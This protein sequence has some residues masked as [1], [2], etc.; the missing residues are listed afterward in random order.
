MEG[1]GIMKKVS[2]R[3]LSI[4]LMLALIIGLN[5]SFQ[6][7]SRAAE[8]DSL[9]ELQCFLS[10][11]DKLP[12][13]YSEV[14][15]WENG[16][17]RNIATHPVMIGDES[18]YYLHIYNKDGFTF[19]FKGI[20]IGY[21][22]EG[23]SIFTSPVNAEEQE[24]GSWVFSENPEGKKEIDRF[25]SWKEVGSS[26]NTSH[27]VYELICHH[28]DFFNIYPIY[29][30]KDEAGNVEYGDSIPWPDDNENTISNLSCMVDGESRSA[31]IGRWIG[32]IAPVSP[33]RLSLRGDAVYNNGSF[34]IGPDP[35]DEFGPFSELQSG[36]DNYLQVRFSTEFVDREEGVDAPLPEVSKLKDPK[37][38]RNGLTIEKNVDGAF[39]ATDDIT[40]STENSTGLV[41]FRTVKKDGTP[42]IGEYRLSHTEG[43]KT[44]S[45]TLDVKPGPG[46]RSTA[47]LDSSGGI[48]RDQTRA[49]SQSIIDGTIENYGQ[50]IY[51][52]VPHK[53]DRDG[54]FLQGVGYSKKLRIQVDGKDTTYSADKTSGEVYCVKK[55]AILYVEEFNGEKINSYGDIWAIDLS[56]FALSDLKQFFVTAQYD[57]SFDLTDYAMIHTADVPTP[58]PTPEPTP[59]PTAMPTKPYTDVIYDDLPIQGRRSA[60][61][62]VDSLGTT[63]DE[64]AQIVAYAEQEKIEPEVLLLTEEDIEKKD[65]EKD[66]KGAR[67]G[68]LIPESRK[69]TKNSITIGW[70]KLSSADGYIV[71]GNKC[72]TKNRFKQLKVLRD[73]K[74]KTF[75]QKKLKK[76]TYYKYLIQ[77]YKIIAGR[78]VTICATPN[79]HIITEGGK[80]GMAQGIICK[81]GKKA[82]SRLKLKKGKTVTIKGTE[83][84]GNKKISHHRNICYESFDKSI[85]TVS[86]KGVIKG[87][88]AGKTKIYVYAQNGVYKIVQL[89]VTG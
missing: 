74:T 66:L 65:G 89:T 14:G 32:M 81:K 69:T 50:T 64:A 48:T 86:K 16:E 59:L 7:V 70:K 33:L 60:D 13:R 18:V 71:Y 80:S 35:A 29:T 28:D 62:V 79:L 27:V 1:F 55:D 57:D 83:L 68:K 40:I 4:L 78:R 22:P 39:V 36:T 45:I 25:L 9:N 61:T 47:G 52:M 30:M 76:G 58:T 31:G 67:F 17:T 77:A 87:K 12:T 85:A 82:I 37:I 72:G 19:D 15:W 56:K 8:E 49:W 84:K 88:K 11:S 73:N 75:T 43:G 51:V 6:T 54:D 24:D 42:A 10:K 34:E 26:N 63:Q 46:F 20:A 2:E 44:Y 53:S 38:L 21:W 5:G 3:I 41:N 23:G